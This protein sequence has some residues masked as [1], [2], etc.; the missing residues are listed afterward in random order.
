MIFG[1]FWRLIPNNPGI[2]IFFRKNKNVT[3][4]VSLLYKSVQKIRKI[5]RVV[6]EKN[7]RTDERTDGG[8]IIGPKS[9]SGGGPKR[10][11]VIIRSNGSR[12]MIL[13]YF[14]V[15]SQHNPLKGPKNWSHGPGWQIKKL[16]KQSSAYFI[17]KYKVK[18]VSSHK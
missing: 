12:K 11:P 1:H 16:N 15:F 9:A 10:F 7:E 2:K 5:E 4:L 3:F 14:G 17:W 13:S 6:S 18:N 8:E